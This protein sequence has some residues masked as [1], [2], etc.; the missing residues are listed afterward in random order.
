MRSFL[1]VIPFLWLLLF[2]ACSQ[3]NAS[4]IEFAQSNYPTGTA[5]LAT[6]A[7]YTASTQVSLNLNSSSAADVTYFTDG[8][9]KWQNATWTTYTSSLTAV[10]PSGDGMKNINVMFRN[11]DHFVSSCSTVQITLDTTAPTAPGTITFDNTASLL[12]ATP[13]FSFA[14]SLDAGSGVDHYEARLVDYTTEAPITSWSNIGNTTIG[15]QVTSLSL[16][17]RIS[18]AVQLRAIDKVGNISAITKSSA[19][20]A[21]PLLQL[22][23]TNF[24]SKGGVYSVTVNLSSAAFQNVQLT[25]HTVDGTALSGLDYRPMSGKTITIPAGSS[26]GTFL[27]DILDNPVGSTSRKFQVVVDSIS[28]AALATSSM[29]IGVPVGVG[30]VVN[31]FT[32]IVASPGGSTC[33]INSTGSV[34][35]WGDNTSGQVGN[36]S[37]GGN[38]AIATQVTSLPQAATKIALG[39]AHACAILADKT[40]R[41]WGY[42]GYYALGNNSTANSANAISP[43]G[44]SDIVDI[45][46]NN[47]TT[48]A[49]NS[50]GSVYCWGLNTGGQI[51]GTYTNIP[52]PILISGLSGATQISRQG[53]NSCALLSTGDA[54]CWGSS[55]GPTPMSM[56]LTNLTSLSS[57]FGH[58]CGVDSSKQLW[59]WGSNTNLQLGQPSSLSSSFFTGKLF[60]YFT[61]VQ[62]VFTGSY[63]TCAM[64]ADNTV[65]CFGLNDRGQIGNSF[66][67]TIG[68]PQQ[69]LNSYAVSTLAMGQYH[70]C[71]VL[72]NGQ[73]RCWGANASGLLGGGYYNTDRNYFPTDPS[74]LSNMGTI[75]N[76]TVSHG[77]VCYT[78]SDGYNCWGANT[79]NIGLNVANAFQTFWSYLWGTAAS[80]P[81][82]VSSATGAWHMCYLYS[83]GSVKCAGKNE[84]GQLG[85]G[86]LTASN[87]LVNVTLPGGVTAS[88]ISAGLAHTCIDGSDNNVYCWG[89]SYQGQLGVNAPSNYFNTPQQVSVAGLHNVTAKFYSTCAQR[90][91]DG[92]LMCWGANWSGLFGNGTSGTA[93]WG[94]QQ[95]SLPGAPISYDIGYQHGCAIYGTNHDLY[96][97]G[98]NN[99]GQVGVGDT[100]MRTTPVLVTSLTNVQAVSLSGFHTCAITNSGK[101]YCWGLG[102]DGALGNGDASRANQLAPSLVS[103]I[104]GG[105]TQIGAYSV[106]NFDYTSNYSFSNSVQMTCAVI[107]LGAGYAHDSIKCWGGYGDDI[108]SRFSWFSSQGVP[109]VFQ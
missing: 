16:T 54:K 25:V 28:N 106:T 6:P 82:I 89:F 27:I 31:N 77:Q 58:T 11:A 97:W 9:C 66:Y 20:T 57:G 75:T 59:C 26:S 103:S 23:D 13:V 30:S 104:V 56:G 40:V 19:V 36:G 44:L 79:A 102:S 94:P 81:H 3:K 99:V 105:A 47:Y 7:L 4:T 95:V 12:T 87:T 37:V 53:N 60:P 107:S 65:W 83:D 43:T 50:T 74:F 92:Q 33:A 2:S 5:S 63:S 52:T 18:Y 109:V 17:E 14:A 49:I 91:S 76:L 51:D 29:N 100:T 38:S 85:N 15:Q 72:T 84:V 70:G 69:I 39:F 48:C 1:L 55:Y 101:A 8:T 22:A 86:T 64:K 108:G 88:R 71:A 90:I 45:S 80:T 21:G 10:I 93:V 35:C 34:Y 62:K 46:S 67:G 98:F 96:C 32:S 24:S 73:S 61:N 68:T 42:G 41:C 78:N